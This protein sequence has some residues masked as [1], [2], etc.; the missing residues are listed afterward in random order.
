M[1]AA[2]IAQFD[3]RIPRNVEFHGKRQR[4][5]CPIC[6]TVRSEVAVVKPISQMPRDLIRRV[7]KIDLD[8]QASIRDTVRLAALAAKGEQLDEMRH[9]AGGNLRLDRVR[10][11]K[12]ATIGARYDLTGSG[13]QTSARIKA[14]GPVPLLANPIKPHAIPKVG[15]RARR[16]KRLAIPGIGVRSS[17]QH[18]GTRGKD[19]WNRGRERAEPA[20]R[21]LITKRTDVVVRRSFQ[22]GA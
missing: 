4:S 8:I 13:A 7:D 14:I 10:S 12:G 9:D 3:H 18:P 16:R 5:G 11:G 2:I 1:P 6:R 21:K 19:T 20:V 17:V 22:N 15:P